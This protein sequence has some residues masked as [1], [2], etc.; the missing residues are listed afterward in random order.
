[1]LDSR[2]CAA[3]NSEGDAPASPRTTGDASNLAS[4]DSRLCAASNSEGDD[5]W[6]GGDEDEGVEQETAGV[7]L[8]EEDEG[9]GEGGSDEEKDQAP[10]T[11]LPGEDGVAI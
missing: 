2:L 4:L 7:G 9:D 5:H 8:G 3:S 1:L 11:N 10:E 6:D